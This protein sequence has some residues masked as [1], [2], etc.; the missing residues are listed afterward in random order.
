MSLTLHQEEILN[1]AITILEHGDRV[2]VKGSAGVGKTFLVDEL[3]ERLILKFNLQYKS[4]Y[5]SAPTNKAVKVIKGKVDGRENLTFL[6]THQALSLKRKVDYKTGEISFIPGFHPKKPPL[7]GV[8][9]FIIDESSM[10]NSKLQTYIEQFSDMFRVKVIFLGDDKQIKPV[11]ERFSPIFKGCPKNFNF[12]ADAEQFQKLGENRTLVK[13]T[14]RSFTVYVPYPEVE[15]T[16]II[17]QGAGNPI[18]D[19]SR[20]LGFIGS[21]IDKIITASNEEITGFLHLDD[22]QIIIENLAHENG[23]DNLKYLAWTNRE[24]DHINSLVRERLYGNPNKIE[25]GESLVFNSPYKDEYVVSDEIVVENLEVVNKTFQYVFDKAGSLEPGLGQTPYYG[26]IE[27]KVYLINDSI[28][29]IHE[30]SEKKYNDLVY[31]LTNKAKFSQI[32]WVDKIKFE[33]KFGDLKYNHAITVHKS[34]GSTYKQ[35][36][37]NVKDIKK[38]RVQEE[39]DGLLYTGSTRASE[40]LILYNY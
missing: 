28:P 33:E 19:L 38:N 35:T 22:K 25:L 11:K 15:L 40:L 27:L 36:I 30:D 1:S 16:E 39:V 4:I 31:A 3:I 7:K 12:L 24:V 34:Q 8:A 20:N 2:L 9:V 18:I 10:I 17:R 6:T 5:C 29:V 32:D 23:T 37:L 26:D 13:N 21:G 14:T